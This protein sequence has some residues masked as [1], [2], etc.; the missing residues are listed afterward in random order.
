[1]SSTSETSSY[2]LG[3][4]IPHSPVGDPPPAPNQADARIG[5]HVTRLF[6][7]MFG[8][9]L[10]MGVQG[11]PAPPP[12]TS[13]P[14]PS[15]PSPDPS[16][17]QI[18]FEVSGGVGGQYAK[19]TIHGDGRVSRQGRFDSEQ[20]VTT[21]ENVSRLLEEL[22]AAGFFDLRVSDE[23]VW[24]AD[25]FNYVIAV[26]DG[27][28]SHDVRAIDAGQLPAEVRMIIQMLRTFVAAF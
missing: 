13:P 24:C 20:Y 7:A 12:R 19:W 3:E 16:T 17:V 15:A 8:A 14:S 22:R 21:P 18:V 27:R 1:M 4:R 6:F 23:G 2:D 28:R 5:A 10:L 26:S 9:L 11:C 25:C